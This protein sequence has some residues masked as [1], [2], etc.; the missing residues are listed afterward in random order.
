FLSALEEDF[1]DHSDTDSTVSEDFTRKSTRNPPVQ[2]PSLQKP[3][4]AAKTTSQFDKLQQMIQRSILENCLSINIIDSFLDKKIPV[5]MTPPR[6][7]SNDN[8]MQGL[9]HVGN[10]NYTS[11]P[12]MLSVSNKRS[13][14][15]VRNSIA[16]L[17]LTLD[18]LRMQYKGQLELLNS[19]KK[20]KRRGLSNGEE[21]GVEM[22]RSKRKPR[23]R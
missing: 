19:L 16:S 3:S 1:S 23:R 22:E 13:I 9:S 17:E 4:L 14:E 5:P 7:L 18:E 6:S 21:D 12:Q 8:L 11:S 2:K 20:N 10:T 15:E